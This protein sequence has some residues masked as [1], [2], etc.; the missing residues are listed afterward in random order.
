[1]SEEEFFDF[2]SDNLII[3]YFNLQIDN[4]EEV[5]KDSDTPVK[6]GDS[7]LITTPEG[8][9]I[10][11]DSGINY[12]GDKL[13]KYLNK[14]GVEKIDYAFATHPHWD[15]IGGFLTIF[16][17]IDVEKFYHINVLN[18]SDTYEKYL[19]LIESNNINNEY[20]D[21]GDSLNIEPDIMVEVLSPFDG[22]I[23]DNSQDID[24][25]ST[26]KM[27]NLSLVMNFRFG[28]K[29]FL[30]T[31]DI[32]KDLEKEL[33]EKYNDGQLEADILHVPHHGEETS[34]SFELIE[35]VN[36]D[37][38][39]MS[40]HELGSISIFNRFRSYDIE[41]FVTGLN[42]NILIESD[43]DNIDVF[44]EEVIDSDYLN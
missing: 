36:P 40:R 33:V 24:D 15:H 6:S 25:I 22:S 26:R 17:T 35:A 11:I 20:L 31:G 9:N 12:V 21:A 13:N 28:D 8:K 39:I 3:R 5:R 2:E 34:S 38:A 27:N 18:N 30:I 14:I 7:I 23:S 43:G 16:N 10:L 41:V 37:Y 32:Y 4:I 44:T 42:G 1:L 29:S 19:E